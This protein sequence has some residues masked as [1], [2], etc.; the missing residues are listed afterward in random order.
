MQPLTA[1]LTQERGSPDTSPLL[2]FLH[3]FLYLL[4]GPQSNSSVPPYPITRPAPYD[5]GIRG[6]LQLSGVGRQSQH[7]T[8][9]ETSV[10]PPSEY[11]TW[12]D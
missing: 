7:P 9:G 2:L 12:R 10:T 4:W 11:L 5:V 8:V 1:D 6:Q 3:L